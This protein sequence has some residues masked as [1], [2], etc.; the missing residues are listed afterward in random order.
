MTYIALFVVVDMKRQSPTHWHW[1]FRCCGWAFGGGG[2]VPT[3][4]I[5]GSSK[6]A[7]S[8]SSSSTVIVKGELH[9]DNDSFQPSITTE[10]RDLS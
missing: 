8:S 4:R 9:K 10:A 6:A 7:P 1:H 2:A 5:R 3:S